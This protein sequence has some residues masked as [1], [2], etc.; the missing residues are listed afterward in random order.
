MSRGAHYYV[1]D[2]LPPDD[3]SFLDRIVVGRGVRGAAQFIGVSY[4]V[5]NKLFGGGSASEDAVE[6]V[7]AG[8]EWIRHV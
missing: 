2:R 8:L 7:R 4:T 3:Q 5:I 6:R 1:R